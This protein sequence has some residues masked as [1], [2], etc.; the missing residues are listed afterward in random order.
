MQNYL[1]EYDQYLDLSLEKFID[2]INATE[3]VK[4]K[5]LKVSDLTYFNNEFIDPGHGIYIF[6]TEEKILLVGK[7]RTMSF[8]ERISKHFDVR[9]KAWFN[10]L[11]YVTCLDHFG[12]KKTE[13]NFKKA[14]RYVFDNARLVLIN[15]K[16]PAQIDQFEKVLRGSTIEPLNKYKHKKYENHLVLADI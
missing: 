9:P 4:L 16:N 7:A 14:S 8:T 11:L 1:I 2:V 5:D 15:M 6:K 3:G 13:E 12:D 10:R